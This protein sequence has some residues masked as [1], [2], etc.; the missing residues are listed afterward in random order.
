[1]KIVDVR[2]IVLR[3]PWATGPEGDIPEELSHPSANFSV[4]P[5]VGQFSVLVEITSSDG[6]VGIGE[7][8]GLPSPD[9]T[10]ILVRDVF[11]PSLIG[12]DPFEIEYIWGRLMSLPA[13]MGFSR[14]FVM[15]AISAID[16]ALW[17]LKAKALALPLATLLGGRTKTAIDCYASPVPHLP[18]VEDSQA[19]ALEFVRQGFRSVKLKTGRGVSTDVAHIEAVRDALPADI[20]MMID[21]NCAYTVRE[22]IS[23]VRAIRNLDLVWVEEPLAPD[24]YVGLA[25]VR[26]H[27]STAIATG[28]NEFTVRGIREA[29]VSRAADVIMPNVTR[30]GGVTG[31]RK[32]AE[33]ADAHGL[34]IAPHGVGSTVGLAATLHTMV[35]L[36]NSLTYEYNRFPNP[37]RDRLAS[38]SGLDEGRLHV[39]PGNGLGIELDEE[40][41]RE[42]ADERVE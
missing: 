31:L 24:D 33:F 20:G 25:E 29:A 35:S 3:A 14:G 26:R 17:D 21:C 4:F 12:L 34:E 36:P 5:R 28:E 16:I 8:Y 11:A 18:T 10:A 2:A 32:I 7:G 39:P 40:V 19:A 1:M 37:L 27:A 6:V 42:Y 13:G 22:A 30:V 9:P 23:L 15:Q 38:F 41:V